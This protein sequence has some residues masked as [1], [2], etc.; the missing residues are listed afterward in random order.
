MK[1]SI[2]L[3]IIINSLVL[4]V[5]GAAAATINFD[6]SKAGA[7]IDKTSMAEPSQIPAPYIYNDVSR[8]IMITSVKYEDVLKVN[9]KSSAAG[10]L[11]DF[12][13]KVCKGACSEGSVVEERL[14]TKKAAESFAI[15]LAPEKA[16][17]AGDYVLEFAHRKSGE[18]SAAEGRQQYKFKVNGE[19][20]YPEIGRSVRFNPEDY[21]WHSIP[22]SKK[23][24]KSYTNEIMWKIMKQDKNDYYVCDVETTYE[25]YWWKC[26][27]SNPHTSP[28]VCVC[29]EVQRKY[30]ETLTDKCHWEAKWW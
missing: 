20:S 15:A 17:Y 27:V 22:C 28:G 21:Q 7:L 8:G 26:S 9:L 25:N 30:K 19:N 12:A 23:D 4:S 29:A 3:G 14:I 11:T 16:L 18:K 24:D 2:K 10:E 1:N 6:G 13:L 5:A